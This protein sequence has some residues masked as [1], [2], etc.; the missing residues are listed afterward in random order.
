MLEQPGSSPVLLGVYHDEKVH[1]IQPDVGSQMT[2]LLAGMEAPPSQQAHKPQFD[3]HPE[4]VFVMST[5]N[6]YLVCL[7]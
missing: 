7:T 3:P 5:K 6:V 4:L 2:F 1:E